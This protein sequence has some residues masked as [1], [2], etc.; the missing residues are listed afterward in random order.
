ML[1]PAIRTDSKRT[2][3]STME[4]NSSRARVRFCSSVSWSKSS[5]T[6]ARVSSSSGRTW[7]S[8]TVPGTSVSGST[9]R[10]REAV[11]RRSMRWSMLRG[12]GRGR[13][14]GSA[15]GRP[16]LVCVGSVCPWGSH[17]HIL[18]NLSILVKS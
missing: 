9:M 16:C 15:L 1:N 12:A 2:P 14:P 4:A 10:F 3:V 5:G 8:P 7:P 17:A 6:L 18:L 11:E 13:P